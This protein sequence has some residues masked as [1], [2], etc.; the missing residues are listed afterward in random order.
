MAT[1][2]QS[3]S[4]NA[5]LSPEE[6][7]DKI[8]RWGEIRAMSKDEAAANL[9]GEELESYNNYYEEVRDG[10]VKMQELANIMMADVNKAD[11]I[12]PKTK[13]QRKRDMWAKKQ[14]RAAANAAAALN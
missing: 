9:A 5:F 11:G 10:I 13:G 2:R 6:R 7:A 4:L 14:A 8:A 1:T 12:E 3:T